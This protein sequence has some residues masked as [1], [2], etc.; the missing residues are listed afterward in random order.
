LVNPSEPTIEWQKIN[1]FS[2]VKRYGNL[3]Q[4]S[5]K[6]EHMS[7]KRRALL[8]LPAAFVMNVNAATELAAYD[9]VRCP[10]TAPFVVEQVAGT[11]TSRI[12]EIDSGRVCNVSKLYCVQDW[13]GKRN[14]SGI[15]RPQD[16]AACTNF[17][18][19]ARPMQERILK[20]QRACGL[21]P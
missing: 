5:E 21:I 17:N 9:I 11:Q 6:G 7:H 13:L 8:V 4:Y 19:L 1:G 2:Q 20:L 10:E 3:R 12:I 18:D 15:G 16:G 14:C